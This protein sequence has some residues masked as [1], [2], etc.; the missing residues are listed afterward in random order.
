MESCINHPENAAIEH[1]E[2][3]FNPLCDLCLWYA[4]DGRRLCEDHAREYEATGGA[5][6]PPEK[7]AIGHRVREMDDAEAPGSGPR[8]RGNDTDLLAALAAV[9]VHRGQLYRLLETR[10]GRLILQK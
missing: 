10:N 8:Y 4:D 2:V 3:C 6:Q 7:Y 5:V 1:C 9:I